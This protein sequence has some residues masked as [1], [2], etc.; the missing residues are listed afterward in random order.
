ISAGI[1][2]ITAPVQDRFVPQMLNWEIIGGVSF[3]KGCYPGQEIVARMQYLGKLKER[4]YRAR[5]AGPEP[6]AV[7]ISV[8]GDQFGDQSCGSIV[9]AAPAPHGDWEVLAVLQI[10]SAGHD[11]LRLGAPAAGRELTLLPLPY[12]VP[13]ARDK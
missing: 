12:A 13:A 1:A 11:R 9:N 10:A 2:T 4:L 7:G 3:Q 5:A 6:V 8:Y